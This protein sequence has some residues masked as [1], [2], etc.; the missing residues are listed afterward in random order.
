MAK[1]P[2]K[3]RKDAPQR[4]IPKSGRLPHP[5]KSAPAAA[6]ALRDR[7]AV[8]EAENK[9]LRKANDEGRAD[10]LEILRYEGEA[11]DVADLKNFIRGVLPGGTLIK[12][13]LVTGRYQAI[14]REEWN[15]T[16][17]K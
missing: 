6:A 1:S 10:L 14:D 17:A 13:N 9:Q 4:T 5:A 3:A 15:R 11:D 8:L 12:T 2:K 7:V 16:P